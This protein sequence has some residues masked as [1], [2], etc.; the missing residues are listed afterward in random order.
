MTVFI[1]L[2]NVAKQTKTFFQSVSRS[3]PLTAIIQRFHTVIMASNSKD[4]HTYSLITSL[5][6]VESDC[7]QFAYIQWAG[8][9]GT[10]EWN[11][12]LA[13]TYVKGKPS[14]LTTL[15]DWR[16][17]KIQKKTSYKETKLAGLAFENILIVRQTEST[18]SIA[19]YMCKR[20]C[21][22]A[23]KHEHQQVWRCAWKNR[24][25]HMFDHVCKYLCAHM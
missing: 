3:Y 1:L 14:A 15:P 5:G 20:A 24:C 4:Q 10:S 6:I 17:R 21:V 9:G 2:K 22:Y 23:C 18:P 19:I 12:T 16:C 11:R 8:T 13:L 25:K 7:I